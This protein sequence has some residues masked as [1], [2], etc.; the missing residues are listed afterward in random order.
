MRVL[1]KQHDY[2]KPKLAGPNINFVIV[3]GSGDEGMVE[4][5]LLRVS[6]GC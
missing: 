2:L 5:V 6:Y 3:S 4:V 1:L